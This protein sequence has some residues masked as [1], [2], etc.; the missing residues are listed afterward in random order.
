MRDK[1]QMAAGVVGVDPAAEV[2]VA[3]QDGGS[4]AAK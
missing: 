4:D 1:L 2:G 3:A